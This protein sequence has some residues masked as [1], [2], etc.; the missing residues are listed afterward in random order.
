MTMSFRYCSV[1]FSLYQQCQ[2]NRTGGLQGSRKDEYNDG[3]FID[4]MLFVTLYRAFCS[5]TQFPALNNETYVIFW[6]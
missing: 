4:K 1:Y 6:E 3:E 2:I 5:C